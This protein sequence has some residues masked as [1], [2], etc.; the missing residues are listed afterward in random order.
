MNVSGGLSANDS[1]G[2][3]VAISNDVAIVGAFGSD[4][5]YYFFRTGTDDRPFGVTGDNVGGTVAVS[6]DRALIGASATDANRGAVYLFRRVA[7]GRSDGTRIVVSGLEA[8]DFFSTSVAISGDVA[9]VGATQYIS[10]TD[11]PPG[12]AY[13]LRFAEDDSWTGTKFASRDTTNNRSFG[14]VA[15]DTENAVVGYGGH[16]SFSFAGATYVWR[17]R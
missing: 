1:F 15:I 5:A 12:F 11:N 10:P 17:H 6:G 2:N 8:G 3:T 4:T 13:P 16:N 9:A 14:S 7:D